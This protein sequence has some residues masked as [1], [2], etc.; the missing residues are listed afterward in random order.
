LL[1]RLEFSNIDVFEA[2]LSM[3]KS[4]LAHRKAAD[5]AEATTGEGEEDKDEL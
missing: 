2:G 5:A 1:L 4:V 3:A